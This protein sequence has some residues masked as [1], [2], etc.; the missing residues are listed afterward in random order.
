MN[1]FQLTLTNYTAPQDMSI[2]QLAKRL[3]YDPLVFEKIVTDKNRQIPTRLA[4]E[5][6]PSERQ[7]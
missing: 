6:L 4:R 5:R 7:G 3:G 2:S 1:E